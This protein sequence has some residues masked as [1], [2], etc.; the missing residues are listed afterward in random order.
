VTLGRLCVTLGRLCV[1]LGRLCVTLGRLCVTLGRLC[2]TLGRQVL[3]HAQMA[4]AERCLCKGTTALN[5]S[6]LPDPERAFAFHPS[7]LTHPTFSMGISHTSSSMLPPAV[8]AG[9]R[10]KAG[11]GP[12]LYI[13]AGSHRAQR[14]SRRRTNWCAG[15]ATS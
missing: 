11:F 15:L 8:P 1:T 12:R 6:A 4:A 10:I 7:T 3:L 2:V 14:A 9:W 13:S 5:G